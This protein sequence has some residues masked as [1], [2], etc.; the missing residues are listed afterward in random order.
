MFTQSMKNVQVD[1]VSTQVKKTSAFSMLLI[2]MIAGLIVSNR[3]AAAANGSDSRADSSPS[4]ATN[5]LPPKFFLPLV[6]RPYFDT[7]STLDPPIPYSGTAPVDFD[8]IRTNFQ[9]K[10]HDLAFSK[11]GFHLGPGGNLEG[12]EDW[13]TALDAAGVP[14]FIKSVD[15]AGRLEPAIDIAKASNV[16]HTIV[17]RKSGAGYDVPDYNKNPAAAAT[18]HWDKHIEN[19]VA[20]NLDRNYVWLETINEVD[21]NR[22]EWLGEFALATAKLALRDGYKWAAFGWSSGEPEPYQ[23]E[24][25]SMMAFLRLAGKYPDRLA[26]ALHEYSY[27]NDDLGEIYPWL[28]GRLQKLFEVC[29]RQD[30][31]R[32]TVLIT[33]FGWTYNDLPSPDVAMEQLEWAAWLY[34][35]YPTVRGAAIWY[36]GYGNQFPDIAN[37]TQRLIAPVTAY[38]L[39]NYFEYVPGIGTIDTTLFDPPPW[40]VP[41]QRPRPGIR[42]PESNRSWNYLP[43]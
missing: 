36:L 20:T 7:G 11:I 17:F 25:P 21:K 13:L 16:P 41:D 5:N 4:M 40:L 32:P 19:F 14:F 3:M 18:E 6:T 39:A 42:A 27:V 12:Y 31:P 30:I 22:S 26:I 43:I 24:T 29:D 2:F 37:D 33:E 28:T 10:G 1:M 9:A 38:N 8:A 15:H 35:A 23:W 34:S